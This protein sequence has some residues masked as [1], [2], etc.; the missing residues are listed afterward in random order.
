MGSNGVAQKLELDNLTPW[1]QPR[2]SRNYAH[3]FMLVL[4]RGAK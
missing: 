3:Q 2:L 1:L 4:S